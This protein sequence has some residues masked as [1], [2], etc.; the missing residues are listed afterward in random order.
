MGPG[1]EEML[2]TLDGRHYSYCPLGAT[3]GLCGDDSPHLL[4]IRLP[5]AGGARPLQTFLSLLPGASSTAAP[6]VPG[7]CCCDPGNPGQ[8]TGQ[9]VSIEPVP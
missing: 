7:V 3:G 6:A 4:G 1:T 8:A 9:P 5:L 2:S